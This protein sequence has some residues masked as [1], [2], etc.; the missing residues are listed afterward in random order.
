MD[1]KLNVLDCPAEQNAHLCNLFKQF[2]RRA[3]SDDLYHRLCEIFNRSQKQGFVDF[4]DYQFLNGNIIGL[5]E[6]ISFFQDDIAP[7]V[8]P[9]IEISENMTAG[10][11]DKKFA[12]AMSKQESYV[13]V[14]YP[15]FYKIFVEFGPSEVFLCEEPKF[16]F[17][18]HMNCRSIRTYDAIVEAVYKYLA[19]P[20]ERRENYAIFVPGNDCPASLFD[21]NTFERNPEDYNSRLFSPYDLI[22][23]NKEYNAYIP[24]F[25]AI[26]GIAQSLE[27]GEPFTLEPETK[28]YAIEISNDTY[29]YAR[30]R[31]ELLRKKRVEDNSFS[32]DDETEFNLLADIVSSFRFN[33]K[34]SSPEDD[35]L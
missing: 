15:I 13:K 12:E 35:S 10:E 25:Y 5:S 26:R 32:E 22:T 34:I 18:S 21:L 9:E 2:A 6:L 24:D 31:W 4:Y 1:S 14:P 29:E 23:F 30:K 16:N 8:A 27:T 11:Y 19:I 20:S 17:M 7:G 33:H 28:T 3:D